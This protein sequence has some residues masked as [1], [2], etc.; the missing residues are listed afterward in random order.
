MDLRIF[1]EKREAKK[2]F[3]LKLDAC[4]EREDGDTVTVVAC[5]E[6][7]ERIAPLIDFTPDG[8]IYRCTSVNPDLGFELDDKRRIKLGEE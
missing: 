2:L 8:K 7:G 6:R 1:D 5:N 3:Y 4:K